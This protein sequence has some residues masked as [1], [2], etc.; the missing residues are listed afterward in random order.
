MDTYDGY[1]ICDG[2]GQ[3]VN[4]ACEC[5][6]P[7]CDE[8]GQPWENCQCGMPCGGCGQDYALCECPDTSSPAGGSW[9]EYR[10]ECGYGA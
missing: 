7:P 6:D 10:A 5:P 9:E 3:Y 2:C 4:L 8:C 1:E